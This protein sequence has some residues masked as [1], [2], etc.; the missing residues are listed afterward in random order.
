MA[1]ILQTVK[2]IEKFFAGLFVEYAGVNK[3]KV[4][5]AYSEEGR[6]AFNIDRMA[7]FQ[8]WMTENLISIEKKNI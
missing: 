6:P 2:E 8:K 1:E 4:L 5:L 3:N 7:Y